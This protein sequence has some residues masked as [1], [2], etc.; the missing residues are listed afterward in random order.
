MA[1][2][3][4]RLGTLS[5]P[6][7]VRLLRLLELEELQ[8]GELAKVVQMPQPTVSRHLKALH[9]DGW[10]ARRKEGT[11]T[12]FAVATDLP[13]AERALWSLVSASTDGDNP[14]DGLRLASVL[15]AREVDSRAFF[16]R[17][18]GTWAEVRQELY[19][20]S[21][22]LPGLLAML[23]PGLVVAD[24]GCGTGDVVATLAPWVTRA[25]G[26]DREPAMLDAARQLTADLPNVSLRQ[27]TLEAPPLAPG[28]ID[29]AVFMLVLHHLDAPEE[30]LAA[31]VRALRPGGRVVVVDMIEHD[32]DE[33]RR[34]MG[35]VHLGF[36]AETVAAM[37][38]A[39]GLTACRY[40]VV[41]PD[42]V[43]TGPAVF[44]AV[45]TAG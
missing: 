35:H 30:A 3:Y 14:E 8:V 36:S 28:E 16:G 21:F 25:I 6:A 38:R 40:Q 44:V 4:D 10:V 27:G 15:A 22:L 7:R 24:L 29:A 33:Y 1:T 39:A 45:L 9:D 34:T 32:R 37:G 31:V 43:A 5:S 17:V 19:G 11:S 12:W 2:I 18:A 42:P 13:E 20:T 26:V 23:P 41:P